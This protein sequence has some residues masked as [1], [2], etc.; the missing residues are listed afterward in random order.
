MKKGSNSIATSLIG[1][2]YSIE[3][4]KVTI[5]ERIDESQYGTIFTCNDMANAKHI[6][7][8]LQCQDDESRQRIMNEFNIQK[9]LSGFPNVVKIE[10][11][12]EIDN[13]FKILTEY[14]ELSLFSEYSRFLALG[15]STEKI[16]D[17]FYSV[18]SVIKVMHEQ[19]IPILY[20]DIRIENVVCKNGV[21]KLCNFSSATNIQYL[22]FPDEI[23]KQKAQRDIQ[24]NI[25]PSN[26][27]PEMV[28][29]NSGF[30]INEKTDIWSLGCF[31]FKL[32]NFKDAFPGGSVNA[33]KA[34]SYQWR[35]NW[36][37]D[38]YLK[39][40]VEKCLQVDPRQRPTVQQ[41]AQEFRAHFGIKETS[42][43]TKFRK[44]PKIKYN[45]YIKE[46]L[47]FQP[48]PSNEI[49]DESD[50]EMDDESKLIQDNAFENVN[51]DSNTFDQLF[52]FTDES[53]SE[54]QQKPEIIDLSDVSHIELDF[55][56]RR[57]SVI[58]DEDSSSSAEDIDDND[59]NSLLSKAPIR[60]MKKIYD[61]EDNE[62]LSIIENVKQNPEFGEFILTYARVSGSKGTKFLTLLPDDIEYSKSSIFNEYLHLRKE[63]ATKFSMFEGNLSLHDFTQA[64]K[65]A[66]PPPGNPPV[67][68]EV[69]QSLLNLIEKYIVVLKD[70]PCQA[71]VDE[72]YDLYRC[73]CYITAKLRQ[74]RIELDMVNS[75]VLDSMNSLH[76]QILE[77]LQSSNLKTIFPNEPFDFRSYSALLKL[78]APKHKNIFE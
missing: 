66:P 25:T 3:G 63:F 16:V 74:F 54:I 49:S 75:T 70:E 40:I 15:F 21:W 17:I 72:G 65:S 41:L 51:I 13:S 19:I 11:I 28:D 61:L 71:L 22:Q 78:R 45:D 14:C 47:N 29:L 1:A 58:Q 64:N 12:Q 53:S 9:S 37:I 55:N 5:K 26:R 39:S 10:G 8:V 68:V 73:A 23:S 42:F 44:S 18:L 31:L 57:S 30:P 56:T 69:I 38:D 48:P 2:I 27:S 4:I 46:V 52:D 60:L 36:K 77:I 43:A 32:C 76:S 62:I 6:I 67:S 7:K 59:Y 35:P 33:I 24:R 20:R 34:G 50:I